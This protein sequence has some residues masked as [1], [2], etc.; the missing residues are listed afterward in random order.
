M[1][2]G[3]FGSWLGLLFSQIVLRQAR[4]ERGRR[5]SRRVARWDGLLVGSGHVFMVEICHAGRQGGSV[6]ELGIGE[7]EVG[8][9]WGGEQ[10]SRAGAGTTGLL[11]IGVLQL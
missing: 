2:W 6:R 11:P 4:E 1:K 9:S 3:L 7:F 8:E 5:G 10:G